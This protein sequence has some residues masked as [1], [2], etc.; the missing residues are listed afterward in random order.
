MST[1]SS[2]YFDDSDPT[3][4]TKRVYV[5]CTNC[6][7]SG[8][9]ITSGSG[10]SVSFDGNYVVIKRRSSYDFS[11]RILVTGTGKNNYEDPTSKTIYVY[12]DEYEEPDLGVSLSQSKVGYVVTTDGMCY[13]SGSSVPRN[14]TAAGM[15][16]YKSGSHGLV[17]ALHNMTDK[18]N[19]DEVAYGNNNPRPLSYS[20]KVSGYTWVCGTESQYKKMWSGGS[21]CSSLSDLERKL[22]NAGG[23]IL[24]NYGGIDTYVTCTLNSGGDKDRSFNCSTDPPDWIDYPR[25]FF[26]PVRP[27][28]EF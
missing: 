20:P 11:G 15:V 7:V 23:I 3:Y 13:T 10:F 1:Y 24:S 18:S 25:Y 26:N 4:T 27:C 21:G 9:S 6:Q 14:K 12:G 16:V 8:V 17:L 5:T 22:R 2:V 19:F 28:F